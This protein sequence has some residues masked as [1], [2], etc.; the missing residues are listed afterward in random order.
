MTHPDT[1]G[2]PVDVD[3]SYAD[4]AGDASV[5]AHQQ[6]HDTLHAWV[7]ASGPIMPGTVA[8]QIPVWDT[9]DGRYEPATPSD[10]TA[11][12]VTLT[13]TGG[14]SSTNV[15]GALGELDSEKAPTASPTFT[16]TVSGVTKGHVGLGNVDNTSDADKPVSTAQAVALASKLT[17]P[18]FSHGG[19]LT[20]KAGTH[21][22][23]AEAAFTITSVRASV[24]TAPAGSSV[25]VDVHKN[26]TTIFTTQANRP[27]VAIAANTAVATPDVTAVAAG[28][29][30]TVDID[31]IGSTTAGADLTVQIR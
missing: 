12:D 9:V 14:L 16:G 18:A 20:V 15:A 21:R 19:T 22:F 7:K 26:G 29:Y 5:K 27:A 25:I 1:S 10:V 30:F 11:A 13:P 31:Q 28:D 6:H 24:G 3:A 4:D 2:L 17:T 23:Y 8:G